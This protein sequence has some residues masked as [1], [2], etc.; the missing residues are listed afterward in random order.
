MDFFFKL[1]FSRIQ[2]N[3]WKICKKQKEIV[4]FR[5]MNWN[6]YF[7]AT[8]SELLKVRNVSSS[9]KMIKRPNVIRDNNQ[10]RNIPQNCVLLFFILYESIFY[11]IN[12]CITSYKQEKKKIFNL[13]ITKYPFTFIKYQTSVWIG[14]ELFFGEQKL[15]DNLQVAKAIVQCFNSYWLMWCDSKC[16]HKFRVSFIPNR[17]CFLFQ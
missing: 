17:N 3:Y 4:F 1:K 12:C 9:L 2:R 5:T 11:Q 8:L 15:R 16:C 6:W 14:A 10:P 7:I 13:T